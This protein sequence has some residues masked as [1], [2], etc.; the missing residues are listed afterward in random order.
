MEAYG[1][2]AMSNQPQTCEVCGARLP[3]NAP[4][5]P[6]PACLVR[7]AIGQAAEAG[8][9]APQGEMEPCEAEPSPGRAR[10]FGDYEL[11]EE[12]ARGGMGAVFRARQVG[13]K[14][15]V[16]VKVLLAAE[17]ANETSR[18]RFRR[19]AEAVAS[20]NHPGIVSIY[21]VGEHQGQPYFSMEL[22]EGQSLADL[23][24]EKPVPARRA[25]QW[26]KIIAE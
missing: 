14:R 2:S 15:L 18:Q 16:A 17:F 24:W 25:A 21:E 19:E 5:G 9:P 10:R 1:A 20:L 12:I 11:L 3:A 22:I 7:S 4:G 6:C 8:S 23:T 13:L 26:L